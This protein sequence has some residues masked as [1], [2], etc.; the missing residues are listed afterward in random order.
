M[1]LQ[2]F[3]LHLP[4]S[5]LFELILRFYC[6]LFVNEINYSFLEIVI[7]FCMCRPRI[8][9]NY[10]AANF[11]FAGSKIRET[12]PSEFINLSYNNLYKQYKLYL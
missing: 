5:S 10:G 3:V 12:M 7:I 4:H 6:F 8:N 11:A 9:N 2:Y 1:E